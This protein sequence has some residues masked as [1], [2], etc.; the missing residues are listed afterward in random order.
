[1]N[2]SG[3]KRIPWQFA[4]AST[5][6]FVVFWW[7]WKNKSMCQD[8]VYA[9]LCVLYLNMYCIH[10]H[11]TAA[12]LARSPLKMNLNKTL[13]KKR[14]KNTSWIHQTMMASF[15]VYEMYNTLFIKNSV[16]SRKRMNKQKH[17]AHIRCHLFIYLSVWLFFSARISL[18]CVKGR[19]LSG[20][21]MQFSFSIRNPHLTLTDV[22]CLLLLLR[23]DGGE[24]K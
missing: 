5:C 12:F 11:G 4:F 20:E 15:Y 10:Y 8:N 7:F 23:G 9:L 14:K 18:E 1:M 19:E 16:P 24:I 2:Q 22:L 6:F 17:F 13:K 21:S 3:G